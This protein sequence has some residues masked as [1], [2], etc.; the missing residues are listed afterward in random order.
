MENI[1]IKLPEEYKSLFHNKDM[2]SVAYLMETIDEQH[3]TIE[4]LKE[5]IEDMGNNDERDYRTDEI[6]DEMI[7]ER[8]MHNV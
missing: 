2:V 8:N 4:M 6:V 7:M 5:E 1:L 3:G